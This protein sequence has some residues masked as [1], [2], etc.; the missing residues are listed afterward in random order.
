MDESDNYALKG[1]PETL[2]EEDQEQVYVRYRCYQSEEDL[3]SPDQSFSTMPDLTYEIL[4]RFS[5]YYSIYSRLMSDFTNLYFRV[6]YYSKNNAIYEIHTNA[7]EMSNDDIMAMEDISTI[8][9]TPTT[10]RPDE[11]RI[12]L[13]EYPGTDVEK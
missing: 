11:L 5:S 6:A 4:R 9:E 2:S 1:G 13:S 8:P 7:P 10:L 3:T 12:Q